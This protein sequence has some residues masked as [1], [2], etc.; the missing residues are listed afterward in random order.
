MHDADLPAG[1]YA[2][3]TLFRAE[4]ALHDRFRIVHRARELS[5][6]V[7]TE[8]C[9]CQVQLFLRA[10]DG[11]I[12]R[13]DFF[14]GALFQR[15][16]RQAQQRAGVV[17]RNSARIG[18]QLG[19]ILLGFPAVVIP[20]TT[21]TCDGCETTGCKP[22]RP[23]RVAAASITSVAS[24]TRA[25]GLRSSEPGAGEVVVNQL[26]VRGGGSS[27]EFV[28]APGATRRGVDIVL[29]VVHGNGQH[30]DVAALAATVGRGGGLCVFLRAHPAEG[31][32]VDDIELNAIRLLQLFELVVNCLLVVRG[33]DADAVD[34]LAIEPPRI[35]GLGKNRGVGGQWALGGCR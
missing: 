9:G 13:G 12:S 33:Q 19:G 32:G 30:T 8:F 34:Q 17:R 1:R 15:R 23:R 35:D 28:L 20:H 29:A 26:V 31:V 6:T 14:I 16:R 4:G 25:H 18:E 3:P 22:A 27:I 2:R 5:D 21:A 7:G 11:L 24:R 10:P